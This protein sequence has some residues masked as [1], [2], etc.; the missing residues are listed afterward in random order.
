MWGNVFKE[1]PQGERDGF[2]LYYGNELFSGGKI[3]DI[4]M[5]YQIFG[6]LIEDNDTNKV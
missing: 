1:K 6:A 5:K 4:S 3:K 2:G